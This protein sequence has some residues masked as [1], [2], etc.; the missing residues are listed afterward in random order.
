M[1]DVGVDIV[2][3]KILSFGKYRT[4]P[5][6]S[7]RIVCVTVQSN[8]PRINACSVS[9]SHSLFLTCRGANL[10]LGLQYN[11]H[12]HYIH[13]CVVFISTKIALVP[14]NSASLSE[15]LLPLLVPCS[16]STAPF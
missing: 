2:K 9:L 5:L 8:E 15:E 1:S 10:F 6:F 16:K 14:W 11:K 12:V 7:R 4:C 3:G 13:A